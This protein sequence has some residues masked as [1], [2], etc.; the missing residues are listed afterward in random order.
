[1]VER[2][3]GMETSLSIAC[4]L[5]AMLCD[6]SIDRK[7]RLDLAGCGALLGLVVLARVDA[8]FF[9]ILLSAMQLVRERRRPEGADRRCL[10]LAGPAF[11]VSSPGW[12]YNVIAFGHLT[13]SSGLALQDWAPTIQVHD[14]CRCVDSCSRR[15]CSIS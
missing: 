10:C 6:A 8:V 1:M 13:P 2:F 14:Q 3:N 11:L 7:N 15:P 12:A 5:A 9:V 4:L